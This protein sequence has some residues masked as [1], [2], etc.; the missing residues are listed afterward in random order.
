MVN[1]G[2]RPATFARA[3]RRLLMLHGLGGSNT[4]WELVGPR[5]AEEL[6]A[7]I[8]AVDLAGFGLTRAKPYSAT[9]RANSVLVS[10]LLE[11]YGEAELVGNSMGATVA[12]MVAAGRPELVRALRLVTPALP[13]PS[14]GQPPVPILPHN[15]PAAIPG[16][17]PLLVAQYAASSPDERIVD[18]RLRRSFFDP[19]RID[20]TIRAALTALA[21]ARRNF[22]EAPH[23]YAAA[24]HS[25]FSYLA[26]PIAL[27]D[28]QCVQCPTQI[29][30]GY[31]DRVIPLALAQAAVRAR[32]DWKL[33]VIARCGHMP[34]LELPDEFI[35]ALTACEL[36]EGR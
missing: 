17:G 31:E 20:P 24:T 28:L 2:G 10:G 9:V 22:P 5:L 1:W 12:L 34:Q 7:Q 4:V 33:D 35:S 19:R 3:R 30:H 13:Q 36:V 16:L 25:L 26:S 15:W 32:P 18:D 27:C 29:I 14:C 6:D 8:T 11:R 21:R 23:T